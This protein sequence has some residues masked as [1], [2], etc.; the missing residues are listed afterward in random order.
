MNFAT[1]DLFKELFKGNQEFYGQF[2]ENAPDPSNPSVKHA[3]TARTLSGIVTERL[4]RD[5]LEGS[6]G[7]GICPV[8][9][10]GLCNFTVI[11]ID[12]YDP[13]Q[14]KYY[15]KILDNYS[16]PLMPFRSKSGGLHL[17][18]FYATPINAK[19]AVDNAR[20]MRTCLGLPDTTE[21]FPKQTI[22]KEGGKGNWINL[23]YFKCTERQLLDYDAQPYN[24]VE[25]ALNICKDKTITQEYFDSWRESLPLF[26]APPCLQTIYLIG[27]V[28][29]RNSYLFSL[30]CYYK[31]KYKE[32]F[33]DYLREAN[34]HL[35]RPLDDKELEQTVIA[36]HR[37][38]NYSYK[39]HEPPLCNYCNRKE[40]KNRKY[41]IGDAVSE[42]NFEKMIM[43]QSE[44]PYYDWIINGKPLRFNGEGEIIRQEKFRELCM[45]HIGILPGRLKD[46]AW[47]DIINTALK[48]IEIVDT[49][50]ETNTTFE[51][52]REAI[53]T[54]LLG[55][56]FTL[57][58]SDALTISKPYCNFN[59]MAIVTRT[60]DV[61]LTVM[62][63]TRLRTT[64][65][66]IATILRDYGARNTVTK[67]YG[68]ST[69]IVEIPIS[70][71]FSSSEEQKE[72]MNYKN[73]EHNLI[74]TDGIDSADAK[75]RAA[76]F[77]ANTE[78]KDL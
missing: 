57:S 52:I 32:D 58:A 41:A 10:N 42:L 60:N 29:Q 75:K 14:T 69:R 51:V 36:S 28:E 62:D 5:H 11:D 59:T 18:T 46:D 7:L 15:L 76:E 27:D 33:I 20:Y 40:C 50:K 64:T 44:P 68:A 35:L 4:Y 77:I 9:K 26:D 48:N 19:Q 22:V 16:F 1:M 56:D 67:I 25:L 21:I 12:V 17:Y 34:S 13:E 39:C 49:K 8:D 65:Q 38:N 30:A 71:L 37:K 43:Y 24:D 47:T 66:E 78:E 3:G 54:F 63:K 6:A 31:A 61:Y 55:V 45:R 72:W 53:R 70:S 73:N 74:A 23:P 2:I